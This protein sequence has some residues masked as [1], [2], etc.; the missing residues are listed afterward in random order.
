MGLIIT[1]TG[2]ILDYVTA[3]KGQV[4]YEGVLSCSGNPRD[5]FDCIKEIGICGVY[6]CDTD[7]NEKSRKGTRQASGV[8]GRCGSVDFTAE[9][10]K[11][12]YVNGLTTLAVLDKEM[13][14]PRSEPRRRPAKGRGR[15]LLTEGHGGRPLREPHRMAF[16][17]IPMTEALEQVRLGEGLFLEARARRPDKYTASASSRAPRRLRHTGPSG[18]QRPSS[19]CRPASTIDKDNLSQYVHN[20]IIAEEGSELHVITGCAAVFRRKRGRPRGHLRVLRQERGDTE[21]YDDPQLGRRDDGQTPVR[22]PWSRRA[23][24]S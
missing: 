19:P 9:P 22:G 2:F 3:D 11:H 10:V 21:L 1:H 8:R 15:D 16:E 6:R 4:L 5:I 7:L 13:A 20:F 24:C 18:Q 17:V 12:D 23:A 14:Y